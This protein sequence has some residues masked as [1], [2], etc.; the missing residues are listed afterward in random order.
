MSPE[1][2]LRLILKINILMSNHCFKER[3]GKIVKNVYLT[4]QWTVN[5]DLIVFSMNIQMSEFFHYKNMT[6]EL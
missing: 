4:E 2:Q 5:R 6:M 1:D 3:S